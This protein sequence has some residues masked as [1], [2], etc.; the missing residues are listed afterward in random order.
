MYNYIYIYMYKCTY[1]HTYIH[2]CMHAYIHTHTYIHTYTHIYRHVRNQLKVFGPV[3]CIAFWLFS[4]LVVALAWNPVHG[5]LYCERILAWCWG[6]EE[7]SRLLSFMG[8]PRL[9]NPRGTAGFGEGLVSPR[10]WFRVIGFTTW[11]QWSMIHPLL[12][13]VPTSL[14]HFEPVLTMII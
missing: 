8:N 3:N 11:F 1:I 7:L 2:A 10:R 9:E 6:V 13:V 5:S 12:L 4:G 14:H